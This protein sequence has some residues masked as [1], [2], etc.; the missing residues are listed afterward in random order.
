MNR[1]D[2]GI[3]V[4][5][6]IF[7]VPPGDVP[8]AMA[9]RVGPLFGGEQFKAAGGTA[10]ADPALSPRERDIAVITALASQGVFENPI[11]SHI[12][13]G[14]RHGLDSDALT[15]LA[16]LL[17]ISI[18][19]PRTS[20]AMEAIAAECGTARTVAERSKERCDE[21]RGTNELRW[22]TSSRLGMCQA[23]RVLVR[24][25]GSGRPE[26]TVLPLA[27]GQLR[28]GPGGVLPRRQ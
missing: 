18:G 27:R 23:G 4:Y 5:A 14:L 10:W 11:R 15:A 8:Q 24:S 6:E 3:S 20:L 21:G 13:L 2:R 22:T 28:Q 12:Q 7:D 9:D 16:V 25:A 19:Y 26:V 1:R 17:A